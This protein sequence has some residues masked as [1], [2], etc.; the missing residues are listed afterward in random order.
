MQNECQDVFTSSA[1]IF[2]TLISLMK[3]LSLVD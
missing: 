1:K 3:I 2:E